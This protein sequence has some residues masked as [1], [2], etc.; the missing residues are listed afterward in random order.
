MITV[1]KYANIF[2]QSPHNWWFEDGDHRIH[3]ECGPCYTEHDLR[4][5]SSACQ[6][7]SGDWRRTL[8]TLVAIF[9]VVVIRCTETFWSHIHS[10]GLRF[11][12]PWIWVLVK[13]LH[14]R[15]WLWWSRVYGCV[16]FYG[17]DACIRSW[18]WL[19]WMV[20]LYEVRTEWN[21]SAIAI[22]NRSGVWNPDVKSALT[23]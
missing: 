22:L 3:S 21:T 8:W 17:I 5:Y 9:C 2:E 4:E 16:Y 14:M 1:Q 20:G 23:T 13:P 15:K 6:Q 18:H 7:M 10:R 11:R 12:H 19:K